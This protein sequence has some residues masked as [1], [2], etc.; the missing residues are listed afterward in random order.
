MF[1]QYVK[2]IYKA[3][4]DSVSTMDKWEPT[5]KE[6]YIDA[7]WNIFDSFWKKEKEFVL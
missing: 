2:C 6:Y 1:I 5:D 4:L 3:V 7:M